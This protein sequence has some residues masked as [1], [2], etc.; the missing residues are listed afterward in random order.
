MFSSD[1]SGPKRENQIQK[2]GRK[3][4]SEKETFFSAKKTTDYR[5][6]NVNYSVCR[7]NKLCIL[8]RR[9]LLGLKQMQPTQKQKPV[10]E[11]E[12]QKVNSR[13][14]NTARRKLA[15][16]FVRVALANTPA[17]VPS[18]LQAITVAN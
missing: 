12:M 17:R 2:P 5:S 4:V 10:S 6:R 11:S 3:V 8:N 18:P 16:V 1:L 13:C 7:R 14:E 15:W 9:N